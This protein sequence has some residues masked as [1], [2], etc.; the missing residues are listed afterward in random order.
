M[1]YVS[2]KK[3]KTGGFYYVA[4]VPDGE[5][6]SSDLSKAIASDQSELNE[7]IVSE[8]PKS[9]SLT[10]SQIKELDGTNA[11]EDTDKRDAIGAL[12]SLHRDEPR[13]FSSGVYKP[14]GPFIDGDNSERS[15]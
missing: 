4:D 11:V 2:V 3:S 7:K 13:G 8:W 12:N 14:K 1:G 9:N 5:Y 6:K 10:A 15:N